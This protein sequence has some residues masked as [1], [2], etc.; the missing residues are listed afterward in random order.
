M[1]DS[2]RAGRTHKHHLAS[3]G[4]RTSR[5]PRVQGP[6][7]HRGVELPMDLSFHRQQHYRLIIIVARPST[8]R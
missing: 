4:G 5:L 2:L 3:R 7:G 6:L 8:A 1:T